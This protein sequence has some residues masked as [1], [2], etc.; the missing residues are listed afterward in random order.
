MTNE[1]SFKAENIKGSVVVGGNVSGSVHNIQASESPQTAVDLVQ[2]A[3]E[4]TK[5]REAMGQ[6]AKTTDQYIATGEVA[7]AEKAAQD[8][9]LPQVLEHLRLAGQWALDIATQVGV[10]VAVAVIKQAAGMG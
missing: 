1:K 9:Q 5:L 6:A 3:N 7:K 10:P 4:L 2:L 8:E